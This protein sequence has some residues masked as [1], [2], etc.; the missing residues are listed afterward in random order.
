MLEK[1]ECIEV[2]RASQDDLM[3]KQRV[4]GEAST[5]VFEVIVP[6]SAELDIKA[7]LFQPLGVF[8]EVLS[9][10]LKSL[11]IV[12]TEPGKSHQVREVS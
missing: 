6:R 12:W 10:Q 11:R 1:I 7:Q 3:E 4:G 5:T 9:P 8:V 2:S